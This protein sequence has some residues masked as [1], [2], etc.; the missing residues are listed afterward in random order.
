MKN[1]PDSIRNSLQK[2]QEAMDKFT[3]RRTAFLVEK[4]Q[5]IKDI[6]DARAIWRSTLAQMPNLPFSG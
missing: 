3:A 2:R 5:I 1:V 4:E 6:E